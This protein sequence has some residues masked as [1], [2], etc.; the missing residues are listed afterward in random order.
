MSK[1]LE[2]WGDERLGKTIKKG[3]NGDMLGTSI[4]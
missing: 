3:G 1:C 4:R 2:T